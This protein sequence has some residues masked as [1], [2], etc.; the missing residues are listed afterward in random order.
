MT[1]KS[2]WTAKFPFLS[3]QEKLKGGLSMTS[4]AY[5]IPVH[6]FQIE[7]T[8]NILSENVSNIM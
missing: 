7:I 8:H 1:T 5:L 2:E 6:K 4:T 3:D